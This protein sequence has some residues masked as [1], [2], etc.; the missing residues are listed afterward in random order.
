MIKSRCSQGHMAF[1]R[2]LSNLSIVCSPRLYRH[3]STLRMEDTSAFIPSYEVI[4][5]LPSTVR[6]TWWVRALRLQQ[7]LATLA[8]S[9]STT[10]LGSTSAALNGFSKNCSSRHQLSGPWPIPVRRSVLC[11]TLSSLPTFG[12]VHMHFEDFKAW[13]RSLSV[14][15][16][17]ML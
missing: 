9:P 4:I 7:L 11:G 5:V 13:L 17:S 3:T 6:S 8:L 2:L 12:L 14:R 10:S 1:D 16:S 15:V